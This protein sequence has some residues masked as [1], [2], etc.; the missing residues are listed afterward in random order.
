MEYTKYILALVGIIALQRIYNSLDG[1]QEKIDDYKVVSDFLINKDLAKKTK[2]FLWIHLNYAINAR[3]WPNFFSRNT[4]CLNQPYHYI[5]IKSLIDK[6]GED[7][8]ICLIDDRTFKT[9]IPGWNIDISQV[10][11][12]VKSKIRE[13]ALA[14]ILHHYGGMLV[15][16]SLKC[17]KNL[18]EVYYTHTNNDR[19]FVGEFVNH[20]SSADQHS[21]AANTRLMGCQK[22]NYKM[23]EYINFLSN[24]ISTDYTDDSVFVGSESNWCQEEINKKELN[25]IPAELLGAIDTERNIITID[26]LMERTYIDLAPCAVGVYI[27]EQ[28]ILKRTNY[29]WFARLSAEQAMTGNSMLHKLLL[30]Q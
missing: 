7:F 16:G 11:D 21:L 5:T 27:P 12:P 23:G 1:D 20:T 6:C 26:R 28:D 29:Q 10:G 13:L 17:Y 9:L 25:V 3:W 30:I 19:M 15:P 4:T 22:N 24:L 8:N 18:I 14:K 2:P